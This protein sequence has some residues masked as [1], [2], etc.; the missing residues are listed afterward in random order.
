MRA[1]DHTR[2]AERFVEDVALGPGAWA[3]LLEQMR[4]TMVEN[5][6]TYLDEEEA[7]DCRTST[8]PPSG[9]YV[10]P[11]LLTSGGQSPRRELCRRVVGHT[12][13]LA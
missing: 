12:R 2:A 8:S 13:P 7:P 5:P 3:K 9:R 6:P 11:V 1:G 10:G 4:T